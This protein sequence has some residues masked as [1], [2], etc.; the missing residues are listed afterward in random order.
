MNLSWLKTF[1]TLVDVNHFT[2]TADKLFM[3]QSGVS[4]HIKKLESQLDTALLLREGKSF[5]VTDA[6][7]KL[8]EQGRELL[9]NTEDLA[10]L[11][12]EDEPLIGIVKIASPG[13]IGL[14]L[15]PHLLNIQQSQ[16][17]LIIDYIFAPNTQI[18]KNLLERKIDI[19]LVTE[20]NQNHSLLYTEIAL[21]PLVLVTAKSITAISWEMLTELGFIN[22]PDAAHHANLLLGNNFSEFERIEQFKHQGFSNQIGLI[23][24]PISRGIGFT[25]LPLHA[26]NAFH[27]QE[28]IN[29]HLLTKPISETL[30]LCN[31]RHT[32]ETKRTQHVKSLITSFLS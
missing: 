22:H 12:K 7:M 5:S 28:M 11:I 19:G 20:R 13:S 10:A 15:Y 21:E 14:K 24:E 17:K 16:P 4:Q 9:Q 8:Y 32:Y 29:L 23:L 2:Q 1:C 27:Q 31:N 6:G 26:V 30:Y 18:E 25:V 3:T